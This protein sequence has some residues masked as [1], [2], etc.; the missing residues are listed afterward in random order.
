MFYLSFII[1]IIGIGTNKGIPIN[2]VAM[3]LNFQNVDVGWNIYIKRDIIIQEPYRTVYVIIVAIIL[4]QK[5]YMVVNVSDQSRNHG[6]IVLKKYPFR[7][8]DRN[9]R[10]ILSISRVLSI[11]DSGG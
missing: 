11:Q 1:K 3:T 2:I 6:K 4:T 8:L 10:N 9:E 7:S 5:I